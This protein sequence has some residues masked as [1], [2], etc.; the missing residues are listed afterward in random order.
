MTYKIFWENRTD[1]RW[2]LKAL[3]TNGPH[4]FFSFSHK[5]FY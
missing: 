2:R 3:V 1:F 5:P 4:T